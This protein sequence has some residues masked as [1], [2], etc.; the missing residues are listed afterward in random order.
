MSIRS[1]IRSVTRSQL[2]PMLHLP[3]SVFPIF[4]DDSSQ[5]ARGTIRRD[6]LVNM[7]TCCR[8]G[9]RFKR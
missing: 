5:Q 7:A 8:V 6:I 1:P 9:T 4:T 3:A 2:I